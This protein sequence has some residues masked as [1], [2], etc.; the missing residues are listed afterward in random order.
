MSDDDTYVDLRKVMAGFGAMSRVLDT[1]GP[2]LF[3]ES[4]LDIKADMREQKRSGRGV[5]GAVWAPRAESTRE[6]AKGDS[7]RRSSARSGL[8]G[9]IPTAWKADVD[10]DGVELTNQVPFANVHHTGATVGHGAKLPARPHQDLHPQRV[11]DV[12]DAIRELAVDIWD[13]K[14][15]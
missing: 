1:Y 14:K 15:R 8:L 13:G 5:L 12:A 7:N 2:E 3:A 4:A 6:R 10:K 11:D 9:R